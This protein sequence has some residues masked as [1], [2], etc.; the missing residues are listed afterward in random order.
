M[1]SYKGPERNITARG[2]AKRRTLHKLVASQEGLSSIKLVTSV[3][4]SE[5]LVTIIECCW[6]YF[7]PIFQAQNV[8]VNLQTFFNNYDSSH[9]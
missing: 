6:Q 1:T 5:D 3:Q 7:M 8:L 2:T 4:D 9:I